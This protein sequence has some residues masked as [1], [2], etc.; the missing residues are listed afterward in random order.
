MSYDSSVL[1]DYSVLS[2]PNSSLHRQVR[3]IVS[4]YNSPWDP[5]SELVQNAVD[6]INQRSTSGVVGFL[7]KLVLTIDA[8]QN[9]ITIEDNGIGIQPHNRNK[10]LLP[11]GSL[12]TQGNT[13]GHKGLGFTY[14]SHVAESIE[15]D[16]Y[17]EDG[18]DHW[19]LHGGFNW[20]AN[21]SNP[22]RLEAVTGHSIRS[23]SDGGTVLAA[24]L[25]GGEKPS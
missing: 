3:S 8:D 20:L 18:N 5:L 9:T 15:V 25:N 6:A 2:D 1:R 21:I 10:M 13:Y 14:C 22:T 4:S 7:G 24:E 12:K 16:T 23:F 17:H 19:I 11:G